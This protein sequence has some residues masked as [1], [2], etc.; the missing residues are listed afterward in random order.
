MRPSK[1]PEVNITKICE[2]EYGVARAELEETKLALEKLRVALNELEAIGTKRIKSLKSDGLE[3]EEIIR[4]LRAQGLEAPSDL[5]RRLTEVASAKALAEEQHKQSPERLELERQTREKEALLV[6]A[7]QKLSSWEK[8][9]A[10]AKY[11]QSQ[12]EQSGHHQLGISEVRCFET[13]AEARQVY[14]QQVP[15]VLHLQEDGTI[16]KV[17]CWFHVESEGCPTC[18]I[19]GTQKHVV[20]EVPS[21]LEWIKELE[22]FE[23]IPSQKGHGVTQREGVYLVAV[24]GSGAQGVA[25]PKGGVAKKSQPMIDKWDAGL[26][27][28]AP[29]FYSACYFYVQSSKEFYA[30][31][32]NKIEVADISTER[33]PNGYGNWEDY[34][35]VKNRR[36][37]DA[38][39]L[40]IDFKDFNGSSEEPW[41]EQVKARYVSAIRCFARKERLFE[42]RVQRLK[43]EIINQEV[44]VYWKTF[45]DAPWAKEISGGAVIMLKHLCERGL[46]TPHIWTIDY[47][48]HYGFRVRT[49]DHSWITGEIYCPPSALNRTEPVAAEVVYLPASYRGAQIIK[50]GDAAIYVGGFE[51]D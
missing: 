21:D 17:S 14:L 31:W 40:F 8:K 41:P 50:V 2:A 23:D 49:R 30:I 37:Y 27:R 1:H 38:T 18:K 48:G 45:V 10:V 24:E 28:H 20:Q 15:L 36:F 29:D 25:E 22:T 3:V 26:L 19:E 4:K 44:G 33:R 39:D 47:K 5:K 9:L 34:L 7:S 32:P 43:L 13:L 42:P 46:E 51:R 35:S 16:D 12:R 6:A 11:L